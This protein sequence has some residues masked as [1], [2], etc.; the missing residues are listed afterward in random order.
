MQ[1]HLSVRVC[2]EGMPLD[3]QVLAKLTV[4]VDLAVE[5]DDPAPVSRR[6]RLVASLEVDDRQTAESHRNPAVDILPRTIRS[7]V[8]D[9]VHH[10]GQDLPASLLILR[11]SGDFHFCVLCRP[12]EQSRICTCILF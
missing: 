6:H 1:Q 7:A 8:N 10:V 4:V 2:Q 9:P 12:A 11:V 5:G 3:L